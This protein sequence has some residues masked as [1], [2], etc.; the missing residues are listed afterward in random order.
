MYVD[1]FIFLMVGVCILFILFPGLFA[2][3]GYILDKCNEKYF[4]SIPEVV[5]NNER[6]QIEKLFDEVK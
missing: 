2:I 5:I 3:I 1:Y 6:D 4:E